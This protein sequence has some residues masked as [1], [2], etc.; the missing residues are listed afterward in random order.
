MTLVLQDG[1]VT[2]KGQKRKSLCEKDHEQF[3]DSVNRATK[4]KNTK[5]KGKRS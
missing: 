4:R 5:E 2:G 3:A 1:T